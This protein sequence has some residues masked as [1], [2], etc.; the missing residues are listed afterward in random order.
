MKARMKLTGAIELKRALASIEKT[1]TKRTIARNAL[2]KG[3][4]PIAD[5]ARRLAPFERGALRQSIGVGTKLTRRQR[6]AH[7]KKD[8]IEVFVGAGGLSQ[9]TQQEFGNVNHPAQPFM[10]PAWD[11]QKHN[12]LARI[13]N[14]LEDGIMKA[15]K[16]QTRR[17]K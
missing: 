11:S 10:R 2:K 8:P 16:R 17:A 13:E 7:W 1:A 9:A 12:A 14:S 3:G 4:E 15:I 5:T 6:K